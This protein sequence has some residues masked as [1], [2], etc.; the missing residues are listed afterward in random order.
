MKIN[1]Y[2]LVLFL[3]FAVSCEKEPKEDDVEICG[4]TKPL[5]DIE[6]LK[7]YVEQAENADELREVYWAKYMGEDVFIFPSCE[8]C[9]DGMTIV[10][11]C[12][13]EQLCNFG[14]IEGVNTCP[15]Y[16]EH[17]SDEKLLWS[18]RSE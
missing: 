4:T 1:K 12:S 9:Y 5:E 2:L 8:Q 18:N 17:V 15:D 3:F 16:S 14:G 10:Y 6:W 11:S 13:R 7:T